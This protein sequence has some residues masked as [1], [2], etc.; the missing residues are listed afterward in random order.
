[1]R[2]N[3]NL[4]SQ[5]YE[6]VRSFIQ[7]ARTTTVVLVLL[8]LVLLALAWMNYSGNLNSS[9]RIK[10]AKDRI[11]VLEKQRADAE[12]VENRPENRDVTDQKN[13]WNK[14]IARR[15]FSWTQLFNELQRIMPGRAFVMS[16]SPELTPENRLKLR[17][18]IGGEK[19]ED[20]L[21]L[22][23]KM[24]NSPRFRHPS[25]LT[26]NL[27]KES[28]PGGPPL[29]KFEIETYYTPPTSLIRNTREGM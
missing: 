2:I 8:T 11:A 12:S 1:M 24:E 4:A 21:E 18:T 29:Y 7:R 5:K 13:F 25:L 16:V 20:A 10:A 26:E 22:V 14:Q 23:R 15:A 27:Q 9:A 17:L 19:H 3:I 28:K 6:D